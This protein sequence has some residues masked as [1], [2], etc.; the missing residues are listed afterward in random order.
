MALLEPFRRGF[1][2]VLWNPNVIKCQKHRDVK[3]RISLNIGYPLNIWRVQRSNWLHESQISERR[4]GPLLYNSHLHDRH[5]I[6]VH[7]FI[8]LYKNW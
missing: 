2:E 1:T 5:I 3:N 6:I 4:I 8:V 7:V